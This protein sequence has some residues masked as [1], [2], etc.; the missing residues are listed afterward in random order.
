MKTVH[1][2]EGVGGCGKTT[3][4]SNLTSR[5]SGV[6]A[7]VGGVKFPRECDPNL[8]EDDHIAMV[9]K[10]MK[11]MSSDNRSLGLAF[12]MANEQIATITRG[13]DIV[14]NMICDRGLLSTMVY[15]VLENDPHDLSSCKLLLEAF[16]FG[17][18]LADPDVKIYF[19]I[20]DI[21]LSEIMDRKLYRMQENRVKIPCWRELKLLEA[22]THR[23]KDQFLTLLTRFDETVGEP[24]IVGP[25]ITI[26][27]TFNPDMIIEA[28]AG[29]LV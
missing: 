3:L 7:K 13:L 9:K 6:A 22:R 5:L 8:Y 17:L 4:I 11:E 12:M 26:E 14:D 20:L 16:R 2:I 18:G 21:D 19:Y 27:A 24:G 15:Q 28:V 1:I 23:Q 10:E 29:R 25:Q